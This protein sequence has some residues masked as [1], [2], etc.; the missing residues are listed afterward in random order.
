[1]ECT[2]IKKTLQHAY[3]LSLGAGIII[4]LLGWGMSYVHIHQWDIAQERYITCY[5]Q[6]C[7]NI[8]TLK[9]AASGKRKGITSWY[10]P[11][12]VA[13]YGVIG[14]SLVNLGALKIATRSRNGRQ[15]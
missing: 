5:T 7:S 14:T 10:A 2:H 3:L 13:G 15:L 1:M 6:K 8:E 4:L 12:E 9:M 11:V